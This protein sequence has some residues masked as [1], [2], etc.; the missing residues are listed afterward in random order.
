M[1]APRPH[2]NF[3][4]F[5]SGLAFLCAA[6]WLT[7]LPTLHAAAYLKLDGVDGEATETYHKGWIEIQS[8]SLGAA[9]GSGSS[10]PTFSGLTVFGQVSKATP[11]LAEMCVSGVSKPRARLELVRADGNRLLYY[12]I[13]LQ[14]V[15]V[16]SLTTQGAGGLPTDAFEL[17]YASLRWTYTQY[18]LRGKQ[19]SKPAAWWDLAKNQGGPLDLPVFRAEGRTTAAGEF[20]LS[21]GATAGR[22]YRILAG[23]QP[24]GP[25]AEVRRHTATETAEASISLPFE[26]GSRFFYLEEVPAE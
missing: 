17:S 4:W 19:V 16:L 20:R 25:Y 18:D 2:S 22:A 1:F 13:D 10:T 5:R 24:S 15:Q 23:N 12:E 6:L 3:R 14:N 7:A 11:K 9:R 26:L 21:W 8:L